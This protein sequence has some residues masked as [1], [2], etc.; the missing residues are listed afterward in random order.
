[1]LKLRL[2]NSIKIIQLIHLKRK[3]CFLMHSYKLVELLC[4]YTVCY[5]S[6]CCFAVYA[7]R[8]NLKPALEN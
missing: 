4:I 8:D 1:M 5:N 3:F 2:F 7:A 6:E